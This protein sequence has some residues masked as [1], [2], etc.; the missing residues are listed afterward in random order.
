MTRGANH[1]YR[2]TKPAGDIC[3]CVSAAGRKDGLDDSPGSRLP[4]LNAGYH[5]LLRL[6][7]L[8]RSHSQTNGRHDPEKARLG[9]RCHRR[10][11]RRQSRWW[12][13]A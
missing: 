2:D 7:K 12:Y 4:V 1:L 6:A 11:C 13:P 5:R 8:H 9:N 3:D 10:G